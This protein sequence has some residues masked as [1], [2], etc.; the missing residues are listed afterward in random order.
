[1]WEPDYTCTEEGWD[2]EPLHWLSGTEQIII[3][4]LYPIS[5]IDDLLN[6]IKGAKYYSKIVL[7]SGYHQLPIE[8]VDVWKTAFKSKEGL[9]EWLVMPFWLTNALAT[10][11]RLMDD[12][13]WPFTNS[14]VVVYLDDTLIFSKSW[15]ENLQHIQWVLQALRQHKLCTNLEKCT[16]HMSQIQYMGYIIDEKSVHV[17]PAKIQ[18]IQDWPT[19]TTLTKLHNFLDLTNFYRRFILGLSHITWTF[20]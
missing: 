1:M 10:F 8:P 12:I 7:K 13:L 2:M 3:K 17:D 16:F 5:Q 14:F 6:Q 9:F 19:L 20:S 11:M 15:E 18:V 4:N